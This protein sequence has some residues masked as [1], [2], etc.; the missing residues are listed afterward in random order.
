MQVV[1]VCLE[2]AGRRALLG[3]LF[4]DH[5]LL[6]R[7]LVLAAHAAAVAA[8]RAAFSIHKPFVLFVFFFLQ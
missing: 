7:R 4:A 8:V 5:L 1:V 6:E 3:L 2:G